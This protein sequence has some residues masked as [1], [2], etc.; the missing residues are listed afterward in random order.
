MH[1]G[2]VG[3]SQTGHVD[4]Q[5]V[6]PA[7]VVGVHI[8]DD[9]IALSAGDVGQTDPRAEVARIVGGDVSQHDIQWNHLIADRNIHAVVPRVQEAATDD[10]HTAQRGGGGGGDDLQTRALGVVRIDIG[11]VQTDG[12]AAGVDQGVDAVGG[13][14][15]PAG[16]REVQRIGPEVRQCGAVEHVEVQPLL[17]RSQPLDVVQ[18]VDCQCSRVVDDQVHSP[19]IGIVDVQTIQ[20]QESRPGIDQEREA[21]GCGTLSGECL[22]IQSEVRTGCGAEVEAIVRGVV[23]QD[24]VE[25]HLGG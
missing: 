5:T 4:F 14:V 19:S 20:V 23:G 6:I 1:L 8:V 17:T 15:E 2:R 25:E 18:G 21:I 24:V 16:V 11:Q 3:G 9:D 12:G 22:S 10:R 13:G 7:R